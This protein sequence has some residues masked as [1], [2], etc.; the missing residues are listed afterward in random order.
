M[1]QYMGLTSVS[2]TYNSPDVKDDKGNDRTGEIWGELVPYGFT[3][4]Y[5]GLSSQE[6]PS[7]WRAG[8]NENTT[9]EFSHDVVVQGEKIDAGKYGF[10]VVVAPE[11]DW[12][13]ILSENSTSWGSYFYVP[14]DV[15]YTLKAKPQ[16]NK[17]KEFLTYEFTEKKLESCVVELQWENLALPL[18][19]EVEDINGLYVAQIRNELKNYA[20]FEYTSWAMAAG[21]CADKKINLDE[22]LEWANHA[23]EGKWVGQ[24]NYLTYLTKARVLKASG[25]DDE[26]NAYFKKA[27]FHPT[28]VIFDVHGLGRKY[29]STGEVDLAF[30]IFQWNAKA[31]PNEWP[32]NVGL[33]RGYSAKGEYKTALKYCKKAQKNVDP[34]DELNVKSLIKLQS[35]LEEGKDVN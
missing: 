10:F 5:F 9:I 13:V 22:A 28:A 35:L 27:V 12:E 14:E 24:T 32:V 1:T 29:I 23:I 25:E 21:F 20:G 15:A 7:P 6:N 19:I 3:N 11:G 17:F 34:K 16:E 30:D 31:H 33:M 18:K 26:A 8:A 4:Q 2:V